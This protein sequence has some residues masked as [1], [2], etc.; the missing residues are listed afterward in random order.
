MEKIE[1]QAIN[2]IRVLGA[3]AIEKAK[4]GHPGMVLGA[5][6]MV[7]TLFS[8]HMRWNP[9]N[10]NFA[11][12]DRFVLSAGHGSMLLYSSYHLFNNDPK[13]GGLTR[14]DLMSFR[15][16]MSKTPGHPEMERTPHVETST[17]PLGQGFAN[18][19]GMALTEKHLSGKFNKDD[20]TLIDHNTFVLVGDGC[21]Q[22]GISYEAA[23]LAGHWK[24]GKLIC[25]YDSNNTTIE[26]STDLSFTED[27]KTRFES[28]NWQVLSVKD[29][30]DINSID[31]AITLAKQEAEKPSIIIIKTK[32]GFGSSKENSSESHGAPLGK[33]ALAVLKKNLEWKHK[34]FEVPQD[35]A[36]FYGEITANLAKHETEFAKNQKTYKTKYPVEFEEYSSYLKGK[37]PDLTELDEIFEFSKKSDATRNISGVILNKLSKIVPNLMGGSADLAPSN[38][39]YLD[40]ES[41]FSYENSTGRN[42]RFGIREQAMGAIVNGMALHGGVVPYA[43]TFFVFADYIKPSIR[44]SALMD[45]NVFYVLTH[46]SIGV[47]EDGPTHQPVEHLVMLRSIPDLKVIR[48]YNSDEIA[49]AYISALSSKGATCLVLSRQNIENLSKG[50][51]RLSGLFGGYIIADCEGE[52]D[53]I[54][55][56]TGAEVELALKSKIELEKQGIKTRVVSMPCIELFEAQNAKYREEVL[57]SNIRA[58]IAI[59]AASSLTWGKFVGL[60]GAYITMDQFGSSAPSEKLFEIYGF[61]VDNVVA[62]AKK[63][64][65]KLKSDVK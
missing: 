5:A 37:M 61:N 34:E 28:Q 49:C 44:M 63:M 30:E 38:K 11:G 10:P 56:A 21:L 4:S 12:R 22:E 53:L 20:A 17:G 41:D 15:Q 18:A 58:R 9:K 2:A 31:A 60:D 14:E 59:E 13:T 33:E 29:G 3:D 42:I 35:V 51:D 27:I 64:L 57:P 47:G 7:Y 43:S 25:L 23:S 24:L 52:I 40:D 55:I 32:I 8:R 1:K 48:P 62:T 46:D 50:N 19:V 16:L 26:G 39:S 54:L 36:K 45:L 65:K 6:P